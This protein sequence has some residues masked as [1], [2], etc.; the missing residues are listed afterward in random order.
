MGTWLRRLAYLFRQSRRDAELQEEI[1][2]H[3]ELRAAHLRRDGLTPREADD[4]SRRAIGNVLLAREDARDVWLGSWDSWWQDLRYGLRTLR[5]SPTFTAVAMLTLA[6]GIGVNA[7]IFTV[8]NGVLFRDLPAPD[9]HELVSIASTVTGVKEIATTGFGTVSAAEYHAYRDR[10]RTLAGVLAHSNP[11]ETT[12]GGETPQQMLGVLVSCNYFAV[13]RQPPRL[14]RA[15]TD[16]DCAPGAPPVVVLGH[17][18]WTT[19]FAADP[20]ILGRTIELNRQFFAVVGVAAEGTYGGSGMRPGYFAPISADPLLSRTPTRYEDDMFFWLYLVGRRHDVH[21]EEVRAELAV[22]ARQIDQQQPGRSTSLRIERAKPMTIPLGSRGVATG[23]A[24]VVMAAFGCILLI[25]CAN[26]ANLL[27][28]RGTARSQ[29]TAIRLSL[30]ASRARIVRQLLTESVL[31]ALAGGLLGFLFSAWSFQSLV[32]LVV[33]RVIPPEMPALAL[34]LD[35]SPDFRVVSFAIALTL[36]TGLL[37]GL[38]PAL[39]VS[40]PDLQS[41]LKQ[42]T[43]GTGSHRGGRL[44]GMLVGVQVALSMVLM[45]ATGL[46]LRGLY[47]THTIDPGFVYRDISYVSFG[48]DGLPY[49]PKAAAI[50]RQRL[51]DS[52]TALPGVDALAY[53]SDPP[54][55]EERAAM[56][57]RVPGATRNEFQIAEL[58]GVTAGYFALVGIPIV[59]GRTF[60]DAEVANARPDA[61]M[62]PIV[63]SETTARNLWGTIDP[64]GRTL[65]RGNFSNEVTGTL[66]VVGVAADAQVSTLGRIESYFVYVPGGEELLIKSRVDVAATASSVLAIVRSL[67]PSLVIRVIPLEAN[68]GFWRGLSGTVTTLGGG[69]GGLALV[70]AFVGIYGVVSYAVRKRYREIGIRIALG[71]SARHVLG[72]LL[73]QTMR[74]VVVGGVIGFAV[75]IAVSRILSGVLFGVSPADPIGLGGAALFVLG[76]ALAA[77]VIAARPAIRA[78]PTVILRG[79]CQRNE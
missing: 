13:L 25:A 54:L 1:E 55:G 72:L 75:A 10:A 2:A 37:F 48:L 21:I 59:R 16:R 6:L 60:T 58:N 34:G 8:L 7:G 61:D 19:T 74:P 44:R 14:G 15:L 52:V 35:L 63:I 65:A 50:F 57:I 12:L 45:V 42:D 39:Q 71:A 26:V 22:I 56:P 68:L 51:K 23:A 76:V 38:A 17:E 27:L 78:D 30:G 70:L 64:I 67:D 29:E 11:A 46:L 3:R 31:I 53:A 73:R 47:A 33:P 24:A 32:T 79:Y 28:A 5:T 36:V 77:G 41:V 4:A 40:K 9:A 43:A 20:G 62:T 18:L 69:L 66:Q 49:E